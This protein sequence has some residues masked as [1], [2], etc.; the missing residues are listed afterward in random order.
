[1]SDDHTVAITIYKATTACQHAIRLVLF[2]L[3]KNSRTALHT[4]MHSKIL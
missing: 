1:M 3:T 4:T 2:S